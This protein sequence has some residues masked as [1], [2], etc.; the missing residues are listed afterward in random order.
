MLKLSCPVMLKPIY[1]HSF[2]TVLGKDLVIKSR[3]DSCCWMRLPAGMQSHRGCM[4]DGEYL[5]AY[6]SSWAAQALSCW[7]QHFNYKILEWR[8]LAIICS[9]II[10]LLIPKKCIYNYLMQNTVK[11]H[12]MNIDLPA[13]NVLLIASIKNYFERKAAIIQFFSI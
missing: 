5:L 9:G 2:R 13:C 10:L 4:V 8:L 7:Y 12:Q 1:T 11:L 6:F 3:V